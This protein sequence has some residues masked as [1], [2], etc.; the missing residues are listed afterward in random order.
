M[1]KWKGK[2]TALKFIEDEQGKPLPDMPNLSVVSLRQYKDFVEGLETFKGHEDDRRR[3]RNRQRLLAVR[4]YNEPEFT[5]RDLTQTS[6]LVRLGA[7]ALQKALA[8]LPK[9]PVITSMPGR[10]TGLMRTGWKLLGCLATANPNVLDEAGEPKI[11]TEIRDI[12]HLHHALDAC[13]LALASYFIPNNGTVWKLIAKR[14]LTEAEQMEL[15]V[16]T[17]GLFNF[18][19]ERRFGLGELPS[20]LKEQIRQRLTERRVVQH[21]PSEMSGMPAQLNVWRVERMEGSR[22]FLFQRA[23]QPDGSRKDNRKDVD[24][25]KVIGLQP[26]NGTGK[27]KSLK[28]ALIFD[29][30]YGIAILDH[31]EPPALVEPKRKRLKTPNIALEVIPY[32]KVW[33]RLQNL[34]ARNAGKM[35]RIVRKGMLIHVPNGNY[36]RG[37]WRVLSIKNTE[38]FGLVLNVATPDGT[39]V[40]K[41]NQKIP[42]L[43]RDGLE[44]IEGPLCGTSMRSDL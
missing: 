35:P 27:L 36:C 5:P 2:R 41:Q 28:G 21:I 14:R 12:T 38:A 1:N 22:A 34:K 42:N 33:H 4:D 31:A 19:A 9:Q 8:G 17:K 3:K 29:E 43:L 20:E 44:I 24:L 25:A 40:V 32:H 7:Q 18:S 15:R 37:Y 11:K 30:N 10:V 13:V 26:E 16:T 39:D 23:R 6:Q